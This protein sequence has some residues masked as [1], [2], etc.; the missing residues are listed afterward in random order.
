[1]SPLWL[2]QEGGVSLAYPAA[3]ALIAIHP[4]AVHWSLQFDTLKHTM[5]DMNT[6]GLKN[7]YK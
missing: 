7:A 1:M 5:E 2:L 3:E 4:P 6:N